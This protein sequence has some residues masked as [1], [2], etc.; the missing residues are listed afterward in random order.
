MSHRALLVLFPGSDAYDY[1]GVFP[2]AKLT[3]NLTTRT[4]ATAAYNRRVDRPGEP[5]LRIFPKYDDPEILKVGNPFL[6]PQF[7][8]AYEA[9]V[10]R[11]WVGGSGSATVYRRD[12]SDAFLRIFTIDHLQRL[13]PA[14]RHSGP[15]LHRVVSEL[16]RDAGGDGGDPV[17]V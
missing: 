14:A 15:R 9:G 4:R 13:R 8:N 3:L 12:V 16:P 7:T 1:F 6:R 2:N 5:E 10:A 11:S 17:S